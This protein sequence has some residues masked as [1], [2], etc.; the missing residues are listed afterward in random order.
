MLTW[1]KDDC[2][3]R[4]CC[5][6]R[7]V[8]CQAHNLST[9]QELRCVLMASGGLCLRREFDSSRPVSN[10]P[11]CR[12]PGIVSRL[13][14]NTMSTTTT[15]TVLTPAQRFEQL[16]RVQQTAAEM[17]IATAPNVQI[18]GPVDGP[19]Q[20]QILSVEAQRF[21]AILHR[22]FNARRKELLARRV[23][24]QYEIDAGVGLGKELDC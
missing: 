3:F 23:T 7:R 8:Y 22:C 9:S 21:V 16:L 4:R 2:D 19:E 11:G 13:Q 1:H 5:L 14:C 12:L 10:S 17:A 20:A 18:L 15:V 6:V 24:R